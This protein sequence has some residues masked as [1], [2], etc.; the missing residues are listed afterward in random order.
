V[1]DARANAKAALEAAKKAAEEAVKSED[2]LEH[3]YGVSKL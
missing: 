3:E 2:R 1:S